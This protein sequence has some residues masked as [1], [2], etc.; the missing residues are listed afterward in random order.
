MA[1]DLE[2]ATPDGYASTSWSTGYGDYVMKPDLS[3]L[4]LM[5]WLEGTAMCLCD[6]LDHH[7]HKPICFSP[8]EVLKT[9]I[10]KAE[11][12]GFSSIMAMHELDNQ[13]F[14]FLEAL[15]SSKMRLASKQ[16]ARAAEWE[17]NLKL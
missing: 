14:L 16:L 15:I 2:M 12:M 11:S 9:Q 4:R 8:R 5:P 17:T 1:T 6:V 13:I 10:A 3:T 7:T